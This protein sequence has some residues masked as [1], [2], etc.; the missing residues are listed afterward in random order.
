MKRSNRRHGRSRGS[1]SDVSGEQDP[2]SPLFIGSR[3]RIEG[4][5]NVAKE[6][7]VAKIKKER[8]N[9]THVDDDD[10]ALW[11]SESA[12]VR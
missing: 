12:S 11:H 8:G 9:R 6:L 10:R 3:G 7:P 2:L 4:R 1:V 5:E